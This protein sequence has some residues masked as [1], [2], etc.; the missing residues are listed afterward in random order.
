MLPAPMPKPIRALAHEMLDDP[1]Q[2][3]VA[4]AS[5]PIERIEQSVVLL[6]K[7]SKKERGK[8]SRGV[9]AASRAQ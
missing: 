7:E 6:P 9:R 4:P 1:K 2:V 8:K 3:S 5:R